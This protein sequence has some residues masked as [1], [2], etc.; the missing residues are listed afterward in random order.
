MKTYKINGKYNNFIFIACFGI[1][2]LYCGWILY[3]GTV[4]GYSLSISILPVV[5]FTVLGFIIFLNSDLIRNIPFVILAGAFFVRLVVYPVLVVMGGVVLRMNTN[6]HLL[7]NIDNAVV[8][9]I[10]EYVVCMIAA[11]FWLRRKSTSKKQEIR[12]INVQKGIF[13]TLVSAAVVGCI[14]YPSILKRFS[15]L[16]NLDPTF[17][18]LY[19]NNIAELKKNLPSWVFQ[20]FY[21]FLN[22]LRFVIVYYFLIEIKIR[23][24][25]KKKLPYIMISFFLVIGSIIYTTDERAA[26]IFALFS[27]AILLSRLYSKYEKNIITIA[28]GGFVLIAVIILLFLPAL[29][30]QNSLNLS[31]SAI[32]DNISIQINAYFGGTVNV[33]ASLDM[34]KLQSETYLGDIVTS[35]PLLPYFFPN[36]STSRIIFNRTIGVNTYYNTQILPNIGLGFSYFGPV[37]SPLFSLILLKWGINAF[38]SYQKNTLQFFINTFTM[39]F[40]VLGIVTYNFFLV[41]YLLAEYIGPL[42]ALE[43]VTRRIHFV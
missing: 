6:L 35:F 38:T 39:V 24:E 1:C 27:Y 40:C 37:L 15:F 11:M 8:L 2:I 13:I 9:Q 17:D 20:I 33:A 29:G 25:G 19:Q 10:Y 43:Y 41:I 36:I 5:Y 32:F 16:F 30:W 42:K 14:L 7:Y 31:H 28:V 12:V 26:C 23:S 34:E 3:L 18:V 22:V 4:K 21:W